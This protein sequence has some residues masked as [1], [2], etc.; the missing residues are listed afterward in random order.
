MIRTYAQYINPEDTR[1]MRIS[2]A[3][4]DR[5]HVVITM[6]GGTQ[7]VID[8]QEMYTALFGGDE[9]G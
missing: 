2:I 5:N 8:R 9:H 7:L 6:E 1:M 3:E 4:D